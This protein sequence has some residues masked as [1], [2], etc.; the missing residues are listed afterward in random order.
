MDLFGLSSML[1]VTLT[2]SSDSVIVPTMNAAQIGL[3]ALIAL[4]TQNNLKA[5]HLADRI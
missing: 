5:K 2:D 1:A 4:S 3:L